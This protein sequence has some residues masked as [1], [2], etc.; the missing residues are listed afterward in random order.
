MD[1]AV[2][3]IN[4]KGEQAGH[5][6][7][8]EHSIEYSMTKLCDDGHPSVALRRWRASDSSQPQSDSDEGKYRKSHPIMHIPK[9]L[10]KRRCDR[11]FLNGLDRFRNRFAENQ[12]KE[13]QCRNEPVQQNLAL[14]IAGRSHVTSQYPPIWVRSYL[15]GNLSMRR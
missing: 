11:A 14:G 6:H 15:V 13:N 7:Q 8:H 4:V 9:K 2:W 3:I 5:W 10:I 1:F 12:L